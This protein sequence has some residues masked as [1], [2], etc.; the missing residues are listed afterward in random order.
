MAADAARGSLD[1]HETAGDDYK[2][3]V[4]DTFVWC[5]PPA[6]TLTLTLTLTL[7][8]PCWRRCCWRRCCWRRCF[9]RCRLAAL[10]SR[11]GF[12]AP[13][14]EGGPPS[15]CAV[16]RHLSARWGW[17]SR[18]VTAPRTRDEPLSRSGPSERL[19]CGRE[20]RPTSPIL[21]LSTLR[22]ADNFEHWQRVPCVDNQVRIK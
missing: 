16:A 18:R 15:C 20:A 6:L 9:W 3:A 10:A 19:R 1:I 4:R 13:G 7:R 8:A 22:C 2:D 21:R 17:L 12:R 5:A 14:C 11:A